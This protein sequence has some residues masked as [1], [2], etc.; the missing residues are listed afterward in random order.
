MNK[1]VPDPVHAAYIAILLSLINFGV[2]IGALGA[3]VAAL[4][5]TNH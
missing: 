2:G 5:G 4:A 1:F 3:A